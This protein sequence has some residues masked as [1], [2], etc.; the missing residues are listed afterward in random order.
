MFHLLHVTTSR[1]QRLNGI[2]DETVPETPGPEAIRTALEKIV[3]SPQLESSPSL[4]RFLRYV[5]E[6]TLAGRGGLIKEYSLGAEVFSRGDDFDPRID[7]IVRVQ[8][9]NLRARMVKYYEGPGAAESIVIDLPKRT[10]V[11]VFA[12]KA[13]AA[14]E[15]IEVA[16]VEVLPEPVA[17]QV[18]TGSVVSAGVAPRSQR[19]VTARVV[20]AGILIALAGGAL[21][22]PMRTKG[23]THDADPVAQDQYIRG[24]FL[25]DRHHEGALR[26][27]VASF[28][29]A[30]A[31]DPQFAAAYAGMA[32][33]YNMLAQ[34]GY[35]APPEAM[36][37]ARGLANKALSLDPD[38][39]EGHISLASVIEAYDW[40]WAAAEREYKRALELSPSLAA[41]NLWYGMF[42]RDQGRVDEALPLLRRAAMLQPVSEITSV[43]LAHALMAKGNF[44]SALEQAELAAELNPKSVSTQ[45]LLSSIYRSLARK[46]DAEAALLRA[47]D[48]ASDN[49]HGLSVLARIYTRSGRNEKGALLMKRL[50][51]LA[52]QRYVSPFDLAT[53]SLVMGDEDR[54]LALFQEAYRQRSSGMIFLTEKSFASVQK[55][56]QFH[57]LIPKLPPAG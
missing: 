14:P 15:A 10:Y 25:M 11:P 4:C 43:N 47:E 32:D 19:R 41:A 22:F 8:A 27:S 3:T 42:L 16:E 13:A 28:E 53:V 55:K 36:E 31:R 52:S 51:E 6:E 21:S 1:F 33:A 26:E 56:E 39:A 38:L 48:A 45:L 24:R 44:A 20:A 2:E 57:Q 54:A 17:T 29:R 30:V 35:L 7:P 46:N 50:E 37:K 34:Y 40:N 12:W 9:R 18:L 5:V 23:R 49:A